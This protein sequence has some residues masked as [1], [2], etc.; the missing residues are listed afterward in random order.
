MLG[1]S[2]LSAQ[3]SNDFREDFDTAIQRIAASYAYFD[4]KATR[5][6]D[7]P[8]LYAGDLRDV[9]SRDEFIAL[10]ERVLDELYDPH[11]HLT[12]N[13][14]RSFRLVPSGADVWAEWI[15]GDA[16]IT[17]VRDNSQAARAGLR[18]GT[19]VVAIDGVPMADAV[20]ARMGRSYPHS[21]AAARDW[22][23]RSV[24]AGRHHTRR[25]FTV[26]EGGTTRTV[27]LAVPEQPSRAT[28]P[29]ATLEVRPGIGYVRFN[30]SLGDSAA[31]AEFDRVLD[32]LRQARGLIIDLRNTP[33][34]G[35]T[36][37]AE[38]IL[39]RFVGRE[40]VYQKHALPANPGNAIPG[41][42]WFAYVSPRGDFTYTRPV[43]VLV[44][45][46]TGSMG[47]GLALGF[48]A[49][50]TGTVVGTPMAGLVGATTR[51]VLPR[52]RIGIS[53]PDQRLFHVN[54]TPR[55]EFRP[56]VP[57]DVAAA[58]PGRDPFV[59]AALRVLAAM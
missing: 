39:G 38:G 55:E 53:V 42:S 2:C 9:K 20:E 24:L 59:E 33:G 31:V 29:L 30:D 1:A 48:D 40:Q 23:L 6:H 58:T 35:N 7:M 22:A 8:A 11:A 57:V 10:L 51:I 56:A 49:T 12:T 50:R 27:E 3:T 13:L 43:A 21:V 4:A 37:V 54:G 47:E 19:V 41:R 28:A 44:N 17:Q 45:R 16:T 52:T 26:R 14:E 34:G 15:K 5:W 36:G 25:L 18:P 46:W 32:G